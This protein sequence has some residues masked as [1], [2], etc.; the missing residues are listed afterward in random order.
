MRAKAYESGNLKTTEQQKV[1]QTSEQVVIIEP[2]NP[3]VI[4]V[5]TYSPTVVYGGWGYPSYYYPTMYVPPPPGVG[6]MAFTAGVAFGAAVWGHADWGHNSVNVDVNRYN[7][8][9]RNTSVNVNRYPAMVTG[10][11][12]TGWR[13]RTGSTTRSTA[14]ASTTR[15]R[16]PPRSTGAPAA[17]TRS[18]GTRP[19][20]GASPGRRVGHR[21]A[22]GP[23]GGGAAGAA[24]RPRAQGRP[25]EPAM[26]R[27]RS[28]VP[29]AAARSVPPRASAPPRPAEAATAPTAV[30][31]A[32]VPRRRRAVAAPR[33]AA[34]LRTAAPAAAGP[35]RAAEGRRQSWRR[36][37]RRSRWWRRPALGR[38]KGRN[39]R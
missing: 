35:G 25:R 8:F 29:R 34:P 13:Q 21:P 19:A 18:R 1:T 36:W 33:A 26:F 6:F 2:A 11:R 15:I 16:R 5:P 31:A 9:N 32:R 30:R 24:D 3:E 39:R 23:R 27:A 37:R 14:R 22:R 20:A 4:Y 28:R 17:P 7:N 38:R 12:R 10:Q